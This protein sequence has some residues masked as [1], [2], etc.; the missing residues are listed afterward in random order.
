M[1]FIFMVNLLGNMND[2]WIFNKENATTNHGSSTEFS[3][4][5]STEKSESSIEETTEEESTEEIS[6]EVLPT[7]SG[8]MDTEISTWNSEEISTAGLQIRMIMYLL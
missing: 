3:S 4:E 1:I 7:S 2:L 5:I 6:T 8:S